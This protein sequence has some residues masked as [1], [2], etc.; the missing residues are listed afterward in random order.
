MMN[1]RFSISIFLFFL[2]VSEE[3][4]SQTYSSEVI[5]SSAL[6][7][8]SNFA[9]TSSITLKPVGVIKGIV[10]TSPNGASTY[11]IPI[12]CPPGTSGMLPNISLVY[13]SQGGSGIAGQGWSISGL[14]MISRGGADMYHDATVAAVKYSNDDI[15]LLDGVRLY[16]VIGSNGASGTTYRT[17][18]ES[19]SVTTSYDYAGGLGSSPKMFKVVNKDGTKME[20]GYTTD[21]RIM[22]D[23]NSVVMMWRLNRIEDMNGNYIDFVYDN[24]DRDS[25]IAEIKYTG[26]VNTGQNPYN[27]ITFSYGSRFDKNTFY[28]GGFS[29]ESKYILYEIQVKALGEVFKKYQPYYGKDGITSFMK[30]FIEFTPDETVLNDTRFKYGEISTVSVT[31]LLSTDSDISGTPNDVF[32]ADFNGDGY[33]DLLVA[34]K[35]IE[36]PPINL[37]YNTG[38]KL[39]IYNPS[40]GS[41]TTTE[42]ISLSG[43]YAKVKKADYLTNVY[44]I[45][46]SDFNGD[47]LEDV[48]VANT[49]NVLVGSDTKKILDDIKISYLNSSGYFSSTETIPAPAGYGVINPRY[50][51]FYT[52]D[53]NGDGRTDVITILSNYTGYN[54]FFSSPSLGVYNKMVDVPISTHPVY[55]ENNI[56]FNADQVAVINMDGDAKSDLMIVEDGTTRIFNF[57]FT[58][59]TIS[60]DLVNSLGYPTTWHDIR[61]GDFNGDGKTDII[62]CPNNPSSPGLYWEIGYS[63]GKS[64]NVGTSILS[65]HLIKLNVTDN[66]AVADFNGDGKC[67][68]YNYFNNGSIIQHRVYYST[69]KSFLSSSQSTTRNFGKL[70]L[71]DFNGDGKAD[72]LNYHGILDAQ[73]QFFKPNDKSLLLHKVNDGFNRTTEFVYEPLTKGTGAGSGDF[74]TKGSGETYPVNNS[75]APIYVTTALKNPNGIGGINTTYFKYENMRMHRTGRGL[76]GFEKVKTIDDGTGTVTENISDLNRDFYVPYL[77]TAKTFLYSS[78][79][80]LSQSDNSI[81]F[82]RLGTSYC[83]VQKSNSSVSQDLLKGVTETINNTYDAFGNIINSTVVT[84]GGGLTITKTTVSTYAITGGAPIANRPTEIIVTNKRGTQPTVSTKSVLEYYPNGLLKSSRTFPTYSLLDYVQEEFEYD[85]FGNRTLERKFGYSGFVSHTP[86]KRYEYDTRGQFVIAEEN[87]F[88]TKKYITTHKFWGKPLSV[89]DFNGLTT[90]YTYDKWGKMT[91]TTVPTSLSTNYTVNYSDGWDLATNQLYYTLAQDP[92]GPDV[93]TW[94]DYLGR[95]VRTKQ[96]TFG[97]DWTEAVTT[98]DAKGNIGTS[99]NSYIATETP[100]TT[101]N[102]YDALNRLSNSTNVFGTTTYNYSLGSGLE[103]TTITL[104]DGKVKKSVID[105]SGKLIKSSN[106]IAGTV[107]YDYDSRGNEIRSSLGTETMPYQTLIQK[108][109]D[110]KGMLKKMIDPDAGTTAYSHNPFG[111]LIA[112]TDPKGK[113]TSM[114]YDVA[115]RLVYKYIDG[116]ATTYDYYGSMKDYALQKVNVNNTTLGTAVEDYYDYAIGGGLIKHVKTTNGVV[117]EK[118]FT[119]DAYNRPLTTEYVNSGFKTKNYLDANGFLQ[120]ITTNFTPTPSLERTLYEATAM[121]GNGQITN[122]KRVDGLNANINYNNGIATGYYTPGVQELSMSYN[123][124]NGNVLSRLDNVT[125]TKEEFEYDALDRLTKSTAQKLGPFGMMHSP[126]TMA[127]NNAFWG[128]YGQL[129]AKSDV[130]TYAYSGFPRNAVKAIADPSAIISHETQ[131]VVYTPFDKTQKI[132]EKIGANSYEEKFVYDASEDRAYSQQCQDPAPAAATTIVRKRWYMGDFEIFQHLVSTPTTYQLHYINSDAG[133]VGIVVESGGTFNYYAAYTDHLGSIVT[134]TDD[135][136]VIVAKQSYD[137]WGRERNPDTWGDIM[138]LTSGGTTP[139]APEWL[140]RGYTGHEML[141]EYGLINMNARLYDPING[142]MLR[143]DNLVSDP[144]NSQSYNRFSYAN[145]NPL[146]FIDPDGNFPVAAVIIGVAFGMYTGGSMANGGQLNPAKWDFNSGKTWTYMAA[147][148]LV[149]GFSGGLGAQ[150]AQGG[151]FMANTMGIVF[152]SYTNSL[153]TALYTGGRSG[154]N[155]TFGIAS[156]NFTNGDVGYLGEGGNKWYQNLGYLMGGLANLQDAVAGFNGTSYDVNAHVTKDDLT[157]HSAGYNKKDGIDIS[158]AGYNTRPYEKASHLGK[159]LEYLKNHFIPG[160]GR[161]YANYDNSGWT[162]RLNNVNRTALQKMS[163]NID[164]GKGLWGIGKLKYG[165]GFGCQS[166]VG[167]SLLAVGVPTLPINFHPWILNSQ[168]FI[169]QAG[170]YAAPYIIK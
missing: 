87:V 157:G 4:R 95:V 37:P 149:G 118:R 71:G 116:Y 47:G 68:V 166:H 167:R 31:E 105:A 127:Y 2:L 104:P 49:H 156:Y 138:P 152:S 91:S 67:D 54:I 165:F 40:S 64:F 125:Q 21:S 148:G 141:P 129:A 39:K 123:Y 154:M 107:H 97:G 110:V 99:T 155:V 72:I 100:I 93:K 106:G 117:L 65:D 52:G 111:Q 14:S 43:G 12:E 158:V 53:F 142:R 92:S 81:S 59:S 62:T 9:R 168:L 170:I 33:S 76:L 88:G 1:I 162:I 159:E 11:S 86:T 160:K 30:G 135:A 66:V 153:G 78:G 102:T 126:V 3:V 55:K 150:I 84:S 77:K 57:N 75:Q 16:P 58:G 23:D 120:K 44:T 113:V 73:F 25:R 103:T 136:G 132:T 10:G 7:D 22:S 139:V 45:M 147:G 85:A 134:L 61:F 108:E 79:V 13:N 36:P 128:S 27:S 15:F 112:E 164:N 56:F 83:F 143:P 163:T 109:Y 48:I 115:G 94:Y 41:Y 50:T 19:Y 169:R 96:E 80:Q 146:T 69:G 124:A 24:T 82:E 34:T 122:F 130:G 17:E 60:M 42:S 114:Q 18:S 20:F 145:N 32:S 90:T 137:A 46:P 74:Y 131:N 35:A 121:N 89:T 8:N 5:Y 70:C 140:Y 98:Y 151:G 38:Y 51:Y 144:L 26:N 29:L 63:N 6:Y 119:Y 161:H 133:L 101:T 28:D